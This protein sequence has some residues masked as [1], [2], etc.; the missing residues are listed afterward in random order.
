MTNNIK[1]TL[2]F[3]QTD[4]TRKITLSNV[5]DSIASASGTVKAQIQAINASLAGGTDGGLSTFFLSDDADGTAGT[6][7]GIIAAQI[8]STEIT[9]IDLTEGGE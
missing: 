8:D 3:D 9:N 7:T 6:F 1:L 2:G 5:A 4:F